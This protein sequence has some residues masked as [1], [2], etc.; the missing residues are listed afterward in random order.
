MEGFLS[1]P[2]SI[3]IC[4]PDPEHKLYYSRNFR[5]TY[6]EYLGEFLGTF[7]FI[8]FIIGVVQQ[9][10]MEI[11]GYSIVGNTI[12]WGVGFAFML[13]HFMCNGISGG[14]VNPAITLSMAVNRG[15]PWKKVPW[16]IIAQVFGAFCSALLNFTY[17]H[18]QIV[19]FDKGTRD[20]ESAGLFVAFLPEYMTIGTAFYAEF[21]DTAF[22]ALCIFAITDRMNI[23]ATHYTPLALGMMMCGIGLSFGSLTGF[24]M[25]PARDMGPRI[26]MSIAGWE[27]IPWTGGDHI[28][29]V[30]WVAPALGAIVGGFIYE[31]FAC[32]KPNKQFN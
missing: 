5:S 28:F 13:G 9:C 6:R 18:A 23:G 27:S 29:W 12:P 2:H 30:L 14:H 19:R 25:N 8:S 4:N 10:K 31:F 24:N 32:S 16:Y 3:P 17:F 26:F 20:I 1:T 21:I 22:F 11:G 15:F 7:V